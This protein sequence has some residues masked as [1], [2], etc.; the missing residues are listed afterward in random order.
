MSMRVGIWGM[1]E[2]G[3]G[4]ALLS[5]AKGYEVVLVSDKPPAS[6]PPGT[7]PRVSSSFLEALGMPP[8][9]DYARMLSEAGLS[10]EVTSDP[11]PHLRTC[12]IIVRSPG[13]PPANPTLQALLKAGKEVISDLEWGWRHFPAEKTLILIT[14]TVGKSSTTAFL[15]HILRTAGYAAIAAGNIGYSF[16]LA[17][18]EHPEAT[19][20]VIEAS[21]F[22]LWDAPTLKP[23]IAI[24]TNL[25]PNHIDWHG[26]LEN[27][28]S[29]K[30]Q[31]VER[32][33]PEDHLIYDGDSWLLEK[34]LSE[35]VIKAQKWIYRLTY[36]PPCHAWIENNKL[37]CDMK[38]PEDYHRYEVSFEGTPLDATPERKNSLAAAIGANL[39]N[40]RRKDLQRGLQTLQKLPHRLEPVATIGGVFYINDSKSTSV[41]S[42]WYAL[43][44]FQ[45]PIVWIAGGK[46][47]GNDYGPLRGLVEAHVKAIIL[48]GDEVYRL[49]E[50][51][52]DIVPQMCRAHSMEE[53]V[54]L[55][56][57][58]AKPG[59]IVLLSPACASF[60]WY[61]SYQERGEAFIRAVQALSKELGENS[62]TSGSSDV[63][64]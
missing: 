36:R 63:R 3:V 53:A 15:T 55:A 52:K 2:S 1:G 62:S 60:D 19:H 6:L 48:I 56:H 4:A 37:I 22:Q 9:R 59:D 49:E 18:L 58:I 23:S 21:S 10:W 64:A 13:I 34:A 14:G 57:G 46:D 51:F 45:A 40:L 31:F 16:C 29:A 44:S 32:M 12:D 42:A 20:F 28:L 47:K 17:L 24:L 7:S 5:A 11:L 25:S 8:P 39:L 61:N 26:S 54:R 41:E 30:L 38:K 35:R 27:Y 43:D 33:G 50:A